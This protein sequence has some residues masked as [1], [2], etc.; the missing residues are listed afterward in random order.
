VNVW[1]RCREASELASRALDGKL[2]LPRWLALRLHQMIC[3]NCTRFAA[4]LD[5]MRRLLH[6][7]Q[8][9]ATDETE[10]LDPEARRRIA[11]EL[12]KKLK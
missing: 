11:E 5:E 2:P 3:T 9:A 1:I 6:F 12:Q 8:T 10:R 7:E 4:Q